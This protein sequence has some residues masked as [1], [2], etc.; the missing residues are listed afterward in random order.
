MV[1]MFYGIRN[2][3]YS[4]AFIAGSSEK[5]DSDEKS[6]VRH[7]PRYQ[8]PD[9]IQFPMMDLQVTSRMVT[10]PTE[11]KPSYSH[12]CHAIYFLSPLVSLVANLTPHFMIRKSRSN[13]K[14]NFLTSQAGLKRK[15]L[16]YLKYNS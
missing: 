3:A 15:V 11:R 12:I 7:I 4:E 13:R 10:S 16:G 5:V 2:M 14:R 9:T 1:G 8:I 6:G